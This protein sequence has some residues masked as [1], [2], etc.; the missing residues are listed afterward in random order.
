MAKVFR[1]RDLSIACGWERRAETEEELLKVVTE[2]LIATHNVNML[3]K[4]VQ[5]KIRA[6]IRDE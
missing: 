1:C 5:E 2:H 4:D 3:S 6:A